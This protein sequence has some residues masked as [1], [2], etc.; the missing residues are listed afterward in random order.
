MQLRKK[1]G[2]RNFNCGPYLENI[3]VQLS[4][5]SL[6]GDNLAL[7]NNLENQVRYS[8]DW[9]RFPKSNVT[10]E[11]HPKPKFIINYLSMS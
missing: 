11:N 1:I 7:K 10:N 3:N 6:K 9:L 2:C 5:R 4:L 8:P